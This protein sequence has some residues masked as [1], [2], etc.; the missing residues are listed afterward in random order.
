[1]D[2]VV[3]EKREP[4]AVIDDISKTNSKKIVNGK[5]LKILEYDFRIVFGKAD[6]IWKDIFALY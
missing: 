1:M 6:I 4:G 2:Q 5:C 3:F